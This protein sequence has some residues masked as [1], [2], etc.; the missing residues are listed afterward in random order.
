MKMTEIIPI[1]EDNEDGMVEGP[2]GQ[3]MSRVVYEAETGTAC[4]ID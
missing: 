2:D 1:I 4:Q 3:P